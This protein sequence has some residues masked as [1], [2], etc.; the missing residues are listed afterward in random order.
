MNETL[1]KMA[2][3]VRP[4]DYI[5]LLPDDDIDNAVHVIDVIHAFRPGYGNTWIVVKYYDEESTE[6]NRTSE[7]VFQY[8]DTVKARAY[9]PEHL[10]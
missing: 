10:Q 8:K 2:A 7:Q 9:T 5:Y 6:S 4:N 1:F 3:Q